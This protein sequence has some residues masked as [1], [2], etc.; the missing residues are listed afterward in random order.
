MPWLTAQVMATGP[1]AG[2]VKVKVR[3]APLPLIPVAGTPFTSRSASSMLVTTSLKVTVRLLRLPT[4]VPP[5]GVC[6][7]TVGALGLIRV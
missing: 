2:W 4:V 6:P 3:P 1:K 7:T 5:G